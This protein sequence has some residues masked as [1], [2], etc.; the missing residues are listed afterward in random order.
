MKIAV[1]GATT[2]TGNA[3]MR[4]GVMTGNQMT[5]VDEDADKAISLFGQ[6]TP[7][8]AGNPMEL[9]KEQLDQF[10]VIVDA[11]LP[12]P[13]QA[14]LQ[15]DLATKLVAMF[16]ETHAPKLVFMLGASSLLTGYG[17]EH[18]VMQ[19]LRK[20]PM[21]K[22]YLPIFEEQLNEYLFLRDIKN[23]NWL[24]I[25]SP[26]DVYEGP[27]T[28]YQLGDNHLLRNQA[29]KS[30]ISYSTLAKVVIDEIEKPAHHTTRFTTAEE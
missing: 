28:K 17:F 8:I 22:P 5:A 21:V 25:S 24:G 26:M 29:G 13:E 30:Q 14:Y 1:L 15:V 12:K 6:T 9:I 4:Q 16:R 2:L 18:L 3:I 20:V 10:D 27:V 11:Y 23:V 19:D 7:L